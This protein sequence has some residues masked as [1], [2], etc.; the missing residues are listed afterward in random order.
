MTSP[1]FDFPVTLP[2]GA[3][4]VGPVL[5]DPAWAQASPWIPPAENRTSGPR[6]HVV[7]FQN[8]TPCLQR[9]IDAL[10]RLPVSGLV[11]TG[12]AIAG[13]CLK[14]P[15]NVTIVSSAPHRRVLEHAALRR[16]A[17]RAWHRHEGA[18]RRGA[19]GVAAARS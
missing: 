12:P 7:D 13:A 9:I 6:R 16:D 11:T 19:D 8:Q 1:E 2:A 17:R 14:T 10:G 18:C 4:Y 5:D 15:V 3:Q